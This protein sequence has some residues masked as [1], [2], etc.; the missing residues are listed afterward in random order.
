[1][2]RRRESGKPE[3]KA[4]E[5]QKGVEEEGVVFLPVQESYKVIDEYWVVEPFAKVKIVEIPELGGQRA[6]FVEEV[7]LTPQERKAVKKLIDILSVELEPPASFDVELREHVVN[8]ARRLAEKYKSSVRGLSEESWQKVL[9]YIERDLVGYGPI[10][11]LMRDYRLEDISCDGVDRAIHVWHRD[12]ESIPTNIIFTSRDYLREFIVKITHMAGKHIS[13]AFPIVDAMLPGRHR[14]AATYGEEVSPKGSTFTIRKFR[15]KPLSIVELLDYGNIDSW[16]AAYLWLMIEH[17]M[18]LMV[19]GATAAGKTTLLNAIANFFKPGF[20]IVTI[21]ETPELNLPHENWVQLVSRESYGLGESRIGEIS[22]FDLV[23]LSLRYRPDYIIVGEVRGEEAY[24]L[25]QAMSS[26]SRDTPVL[27]KREEGAVELIPIGEF[28]DRFYSEGEEWVPKRLEGYYTLSHD[29]FSAV[30]KPIK[31]VLRHRVDEVYEVLLEDGGSVRATGSHSVFTLDPETLDVVEKPVA[32]LKPGDFLVTFV[33]RSPAHRDYAEIDALALFKER[34]GIEVT[35]LPAELRALTGGKN[36]IPLAEYL[37]L[38]EERGEHSSVKVRVKRS[39]YALPARVPLDEDLAFVFGAYIADG[40][41]KKHKGGRICFTFGVEERGIALRV[42]EVLQRKFGVRP[43]VDDR[44]SYAIYEFNHTL[45]AELFEKLLGGK[46]PEKR[47]PPHLWVSPPSVV[48]EFFEG[49]KADSRRTLKK[50][51]VCFSTASEK[52]AHQLVWLA[53]IAGFYSTLSVEGGRSGN[54]DKRY[55]AVRVYLDK[56]HRKPNAG[57]RVPVELLKRLRGLAKPK[58]M[59]LEL[60]YVWRRR[61]VSKKT[62]LKVVKWVLEKGDLNYEARTYLSRLLQLMSGDLLLVKVKDVKKVPYRGFVYDLSVPDSESFFGGSTP[63]LLHNTGHGGL[64]TMHAD[65]LERAVKRLTS[66]PM[67][68]SPAYIPSLNIALLTERTILPK[69]GFARRVKHIWEVEDYEKYREIVR[70]NPVT[71]KHEITSE[72]YHLR[73]LGE[74]LGKSHRELLSEIERRRAVLEWLKAKGIKEAAEVFKVIN[75]YYMYPNEVYAQASEELKELG[76]TVAPVK[77]K[78][79][80]TVEVVPKVAP[81]PTAAPRAATEPARLSP[82][83]LEPRP[84]PQREV[85]T[86]A[87]SDIE[88]AVDLSADARMVLRSLVTLGGEADH[89][90]LLSLTPLPRERLSKAIGELSGK[91]LITP[92]LLYIDNRPMMG[93]RLTSDGHEVAKKLRLSQASS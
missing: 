57:E 56:K 65:S 19:I 30:W 62:A 16:S 86:S 50:R 53:R 3:R 74:K 70:W 21:E 35:D 64:S 54:E 25:F 8:E 82:E 26:V 87:A 72:S 63:V 11:V 23:K 2:K 13:A 81:L 48:R 24:V 92:I 66:P 91:R 47:V 43:T 75:K 80:V 83:P 4:E 27:I 78:P 60:T 55:Y 85:G 49:L 93:Y 90:S 44:G 14:L 45:L 9:Y 22:L 10:E 39:K 58:S 1:V 73:I 42:A 59:P 31:Y 67:N 6:Y 18:T 32:H 76:I 5:A 7:K 38:E 33:K 77:I 52:L 89:N 15:E 28:V 61:S 40:C 79:R 68:V 36:P 41:V 17:K 29:G 88:V 84:Q 71:D 51:Y 69:G 46:L 12:Y 34:G 37:R 20:K